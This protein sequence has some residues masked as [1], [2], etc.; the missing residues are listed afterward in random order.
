MCVCLYV[1]ERRDDRRKWSSVSICVR[2]RVILLT[3]VYVCVCVYT[4]RTARICR[5]ERRIVVIAYFISGEIGRRGR[6]NRQEAEEPNDIPDRSVIS[7]QSYEAGLH[8]REIV[9]RMR[10][11]KR[12]QQRERPTVASSSQRYVAACVQ[13]IRHGR[14]YPYTYTRARARAR[15]RAI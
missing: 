13:H 6:Y 7:V 15:E 3:C 14:T 8:L 12:R 1:C 5:R 4:A 10:K 9:A 11:A 2:V